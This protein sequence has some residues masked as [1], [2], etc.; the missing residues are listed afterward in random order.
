MTGGTIQRIELVFDA[1]AA[2]LLGASTALVLLQ[3]D[4]SNG[5]AAVGA[6]VVFA[7]G[8]YGLRSVEPESARHLL[9]QFSAS[10]L[11][12][13]EPAELL[14]DDALTE[15][16]PDSRVVRLFDCAA[17]TASPG[18]DYPDASQALYDALAKLRHSVR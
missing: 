13:D 7:W 3:F 14:L 12:V 1:A 17:M 11:H 16:G 2:V 8:F 9:P 10:D 5:Y 6:V 15:I 4:A 18:P